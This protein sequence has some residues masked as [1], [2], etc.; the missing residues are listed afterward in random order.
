MQYFYRVP[1]LFGF[2]PLLEYEV[3]IEMNSGT[4]TRLSAV[5]CVAYRNRTKMHATCFHHE[6]QHLTGL[7]Y[8]TSARRIVP[9]FAY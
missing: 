8:M 7:T 9:Y 5:R 2:I 1:S 4:A 3:L 6:R